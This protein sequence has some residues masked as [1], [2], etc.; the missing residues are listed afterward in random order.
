MEWIEHE[1][2]SFL[3]WNGQQELSKLRDNRHQP[4]F[5]PL[6]C[7]G[8]DTQHRETVRVQVNHQSFVTL[9]VQFQRFGQ[10]QTGEP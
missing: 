4:V 1:T 7:L 6:L 10:T 5:V 9:P 8:T 2:G 3:F